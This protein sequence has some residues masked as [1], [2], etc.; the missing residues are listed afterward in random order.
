MGVNIALPAEA[1]EGREGEKRQD[2]KGAEGE[3]AGEE[4]REKGRERE[5]HPAEGKPPGQ[6]HATEQ[7]L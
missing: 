6:G 1:W 4:Q 7:L 3:E 5:T 2:G